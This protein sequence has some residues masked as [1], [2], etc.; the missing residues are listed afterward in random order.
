[1]LHKN[2]AIWILNH[3]YFLGSEI[4]QIDDNKT[5][6]CNLYLMSIVIQSMLQ[7]DVNAVNKSVIIARSIWYWYDD[8]EDDF[9]QEINELANDDLFDNNLINKLMN[10]QSTLLLFAFQRSYFWDLIDHLY[11]QR[12]DWNY[13]KLD[14]KNLQIKN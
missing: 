4:F 5:K 7:N 8:E 3:D 1:M 11:V 9:K 14:Q 6:T 10:I 2:N 13:T 12:N